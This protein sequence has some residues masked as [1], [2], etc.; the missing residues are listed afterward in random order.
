MKQCRIC[1]EV[2]KKSQF[3]YIKYFDSHHSICK[4]CESKEKRKKKK[5]TEQHIKEHGVTPKV[6]ANMETKVDPNAKEQAKKA[7]IKKKPTSEV[8]P[9]KNVKTLNSVCG[10]IWIPALIFVIYTLLNNLYL[11]AAMSV[12]VTLLFG[13]IVKELNKAYVEGI[14]EEIFTEYVSIR[15]DLVDQEIR[16]RKEY[17]KFYSTT[18]WRL[19]RD[20]FLKTQKREKGFYICNYCKRQFSD[21]NIT[22]DHYKPRSKFPELAL[23]INNLRVACRSCNSSKGAKLI[24]E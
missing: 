2:K 15:Q 9:Y 10:V 8:T 3:R 7:I 5:E 20:S 22:V 21:W 17:S 18:E 11:Y 13:L 16:D 12:L 14:D 4:M 19:T 24:V 23:D 6:L 1:G